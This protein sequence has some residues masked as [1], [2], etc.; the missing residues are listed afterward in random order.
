MALQAYAI[1][2]TGYAAA[3]VL[4]PCFYALQQPKTPFRISLI[5]MALN[6][7][8][9]FLN[10]RFL[11]F[12]HVGLALTTSVVAILN[13]AQLSGA[14]GRRID[15][16]AP[17]EWLSFLGRVGVATALSGWI[18]WWAEGV[19]QAH[20][21][22]GVWRAPG[23]LLAITSAA[24]TYFLAARLLNVHEASE[25]LSLVRR[26]LTRRSPAKAAQQA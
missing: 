25:A 15:L 12:G 2:L 10:A 5:G 13:C 23:L 6:F 11:N 16:G 3:K 1:G 14:L 22:S 21:T 17:L 20:V 24:L 19:L 8:L 4:T 18:A 9:N 26:R 7:G